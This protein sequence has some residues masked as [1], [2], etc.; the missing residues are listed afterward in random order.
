MQARKEGIVRLRAG[1]FALVMS[2]S[3]AIFIMATAQ[4][5]KNSFFASLLS[6]RSDIECLPLNLVSGDLQTKKLL[7]KLQCFSLKGETGQELTVESDV[8]VVLVR[9]SGSSQTFNGLT[10]ISLLTEAYQIRIKPHKDKAHEVKFLLSGAAETLPANNGNQKPQSFRIEGSYNIKENPPFKDDQKLK[11]IVNNAVSFVAR[12]GLS[13]QR[14][15]ISIVDLNSS[16]LSYAAYQDQTPRFPASVPK[17]FWMVALYGQY[18]SGMLAEDAVSES[19]VYKMIQKSDNEPASRVVD[20]ITLTSSGSELSPADLQTWLNKRLWI[21]R[22]F[23]NAGYRNINI[24]QKNFP[25]PYLDIKAPVGRDLQ[26][27]QVNGKDSA[28]FRNYLTTYSVA[29]LLY[30]IDTDQAISKNYSQKMKQYLQRD[31]HPDAWQHIEYNS[32][33]GFLGEYL[34]VDTYFAS[35]V[36]WTSDSRGDAAI[37]ATPDGKSRYILVILGEGKEFADDWEIFPKVSRLIYDQMI[38][39]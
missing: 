28:P 1:V 22:F 33:K 34:P 17:L 15:S 19:D 7:D 24:T 14:L 6:G 37:I 4:D 21:N 18:T 26:L 27:R 2:I 13:E 38:A 30:E 16:S 36:G 10:K 25:I 35:K 5:G 11:R 12:R 29:R 8:Q 32:I 3:L 39:R 23:E 20:Q 31:L 9:A